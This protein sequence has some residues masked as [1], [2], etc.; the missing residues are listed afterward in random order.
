MLFFYSI[1]KNS[2]Y[3]NL[4]GKFMKHFNS[5]SFVVRKVYK[6]IKIV[7]NQD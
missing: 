2:T 5:K 7:Y 6:F 3:I 4:D 1:S